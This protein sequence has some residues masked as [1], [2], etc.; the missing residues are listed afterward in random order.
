MKGREKSIKESSLVF[1]SRRSTEVR[2]LRPAFWAIQPEIKKKEK[3]LQPSSN[4]QMASYLLSMAS[5]LEAM[6]SN[7]VAMASNLVAMA[8]NL[9]AMASNLLAPSK[10]LRH[11]LWDTESRFL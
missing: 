1:L 6:A 10:R 11:I 3:R 4:G 7:L 2:V 9:E 8:S 5:N